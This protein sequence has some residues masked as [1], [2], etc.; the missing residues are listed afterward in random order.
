MKFLRNHLFVCIATLLAAAILTGIFFTNF[1]LFNLG[2][3]EI[4]RI[5]DNEL[6]EFVTA[7]LLIIVGLSLDLVRARQIARRRAETN[8]QRLQVLKATMRT[9]HDLMNNFLNNLQLF[10]MEAEEGPLT[11][12]SLELFDDLIS[13][14]AEKLKALGDSEL[15][16][17][18]QMASGVGILPQDRGEGVIAA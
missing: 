3:K 14:T 7:F 8:E 4:L 9:V 15:V 17:E 12:E 1:D 16:I 11:P 5:E 2:F 13:G 18:Y 6:D 10:R